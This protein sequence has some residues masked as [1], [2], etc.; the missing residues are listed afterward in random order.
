MNLNTPAGNRAV[1]AAA[2][3][4]YRFAIVADQRVDKDCDS[5]VCP[6]EKLEQQWPD[7]HAQFMGRARQAL[8]SAIESMFGSGDTTTATITFVSKNIH[9]S[10]KEIEARTI[11]EAVMMAVDAFLNGDSEQ[12]WGPEQ[13]T[14]TFALRRGEVPMSHADI[15]A[16]LRETVSGQ[17]FYAHRYEGR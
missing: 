8:L 9:S 4:L 7:V 15:A 5:L 1:E 3:T 11:K 12:S 17:E 2:A 16:E 14:F 10:S 6:W 13:W